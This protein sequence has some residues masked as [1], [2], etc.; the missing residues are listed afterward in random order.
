MNLIYEINLT[1]MKTA[2]LNICVQKKAEKCFGSSKAP[3]STQQLKLPVN[4]NIGDC[5]QLNSQPREKW[6]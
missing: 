5:N 3:S 1:N 6:K 2:H 4:K